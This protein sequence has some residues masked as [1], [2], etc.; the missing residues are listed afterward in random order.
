MQRS[1]TPIVVKNPQSNGKKNIVI[2]YAC[3]CFYVLSCIVLCVVYFCSLVCM[4][5]FVY[6]YYLNW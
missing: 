5:M 3:V 4:C 2:Y 6:L 1:K